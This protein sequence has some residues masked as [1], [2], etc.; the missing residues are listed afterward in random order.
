MSII[1]SILRRVG[2]GI[3]WPFKKLSRE[4]SEEV[5]EKTTVVITAGFDRLEIEAPYM[6]K[7]V[8]EGEISGTATIGGVPIPIHIK[9]N[10]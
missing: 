2:D 10:L 3:A 5:A 7:L 8:R 4:A 1:E 9:L 6:V